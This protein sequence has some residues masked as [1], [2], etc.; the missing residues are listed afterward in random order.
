M[1]NRRQT[2]FTLIELITTIVILAV[3]ATAIMGVFTSTIKT[4]AD[5]VIQ[6]QA[7]SIAEAYMEEIL[8][9]PFSDPDGIGG[10]N[11]S[12]YD[13]VF[14]YDGLNDVGARDQDDNAI[15]SLADY[16][17]TVSVANDALNGIASADAALITVTADHTVLDPIVLQGYR[18]NY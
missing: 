9:K 15:A 6:Q 3:A 12:N 11:R 5:P 7:V 18:A 8:L 1:S 14:D 17:V 16:T 4:S 2:A 13:D 10:E